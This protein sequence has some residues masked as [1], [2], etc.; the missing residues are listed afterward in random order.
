MKGSPH[1]RVALAALAALVVLAA[2]I[3]NASC[4]ARPR[5]LVQPQ[6]TAG[7]LFETAENCLACHTAD[8]TSASKALRRRLYACQKPA[9]TQRL[10]PVE[11]GAG[12]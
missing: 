9:C 6:A 8:A 11:P 2:A 4:G 5:T 1:A 3:V 10:S 7:P 12:G